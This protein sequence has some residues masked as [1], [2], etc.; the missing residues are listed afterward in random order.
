MDTTK[1]IRE[2][3]DG[4]RKTFVGCKVMMTPCI[5][6][7]PDDQRCRLFDLIRCFNEFTEDN[8]PHGEHDFGSIELD[9]QIYFWKFDYFDPSM[10]YG[11]DDPSDSTNTMRVLTIMH[12][13][14]Y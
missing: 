10:E 7:L 6:L 14:E 12:R 9:G 11:S 5:L 3:N 2:L 4:C 1:A 8:D 13:S